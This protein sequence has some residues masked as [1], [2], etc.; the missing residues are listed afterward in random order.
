MSFN[1]IA[2]YEASRNALILADRALRAD[3]KKGQLSELEALADKVV[4]DVRAAEAASIWNQDYEGIPHPF[5]GMEFL[6]GT[7]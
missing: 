4:R 7:Y 2:E 5:P 6:T 1:S 3:H